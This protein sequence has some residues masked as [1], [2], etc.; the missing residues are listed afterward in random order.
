M[1]FSLKSTM[2]AIRLIVILLCCYGAGYGY[3]GAFTVSGNKVYDGMAALLP[4]YIML[5]SL[6]IL[7]ILGLYYIVILVIKHYKR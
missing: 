6:G 5:G 2:K 1:T 7:T 3:W 4:F